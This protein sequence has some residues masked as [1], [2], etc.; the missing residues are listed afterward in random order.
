MR[1]TTTKEPNKLKKENE[2]EKECVG[3]IEGGKKEREE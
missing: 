3:R 2:K 1:K